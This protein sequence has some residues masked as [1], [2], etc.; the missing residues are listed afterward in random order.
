MQSKNN[1]R[2]VVDTY[3]EKLLVNV[4]DV[5]Y[6]RTSKSQKLHLIYTL[7]DSQIIGRGALSSLAT[8]LAE[9]GFILTNQSTL[10]NTKHITHFN[11]KLLGLDNGDV[12]N[13]SRRNLKN[14]ELFC[15]ANHLR[16]ERV[17]TMDIIFDI[18][19]TLLYSADMYIFFMLYST[20]KDDLIITLFLVF[21]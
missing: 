9:H 16:Y 17:N 11:D 12:I 4:N 2:I 7:R 20:T 18:M 14:S 15:K 21:L 5:I 10:V 13:I 1:I 8:S 6:I 3:N 19:P